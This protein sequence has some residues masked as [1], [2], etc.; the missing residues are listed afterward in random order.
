VLLNLDVPEALDV[1]FFGVVVAFVAG[2]FT[3]Y[4]RDAQGE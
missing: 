2:C 1:L 4:F 3:V